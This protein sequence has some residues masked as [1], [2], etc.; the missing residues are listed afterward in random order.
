MSSSETISRR[1]RGKWRL[2]A[3]RA[4]L[5]MM[6]D[7]SLDRV[8]NQVDQL[9]VGNHADG[10]LRHAAE[11]WIRGVVMGAL[12]AH[13]CVVGEPASVPIQAPVPGAVG[14]VGRVDKEV[15]LLPRRH[16]DLGM[17]IEIAVQA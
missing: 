8:A 16:S 15:Q 4:P 14:R 6:G 9:R 10:A 13:G 5:E 1:S 12:A 3:G 2:V 11:E 7:E 17:L